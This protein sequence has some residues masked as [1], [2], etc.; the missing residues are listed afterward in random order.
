MLHKQ[1]LMKLFKRHPVLLQKQRQ[2]RMKNEQIHLWFRNK[3]NEEKK[4]Q[5]MSSLSWLKKFQQ[6]S[7]RKIAERKA[8]LKL[9]KIMQ[10][11][12]KLKLLTT[13]MLWWA[14]SKF[15]NSLTQ[16][17]K[18]VVVKSSTQTE[19]AS[20]FTPRLSCW[21]DTKTVGTDWNFFCRNIDSG[22]TRIKVHTK[23]PTALRLR[24]SLALLVVSRWL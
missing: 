23:E 9:W 21:A 18:E 1:G 5:K 8:F 10:L 24:I 7:K 2:D 19:D 6:T 13:W 15:C 17:L 3:Y 16:I 22:L 11:C 20:C 14:P 12:E 4:K